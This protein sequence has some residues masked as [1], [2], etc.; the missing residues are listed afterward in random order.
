MVM[1]RR[2]AIQ[3]LG[4]FG[5]LLL[6]E[7]ANAQSTLSIERAGITSLGDSQWQLDREVAPATREFAQRYLIPV[8]VMPSDLKTRVSI[9]V[10]VPAE[11]VPMRSRSQLRYQLAKVEG[12]AYQTPITFDD[13]SKG[14]NEDA[15][16]QLRYS[17]DTGRLDPELSGLYT[18][19]IDAEN[20][21]QKQGE[22]KF[23][24]VVAPR[25]IYV[26]EQKGVL[27]DG[28]QIDIESLMVTDIKLPGAQQTLRSVDQL[29]GEQGRVMVG[30][31][32]GANEL[33]SGL[34]RVQGS[35]RWFA[36]EKTAGLVTKLDSYDSNLI[37]QAS[38]FAGAVNF[39]A[40]GL[41]DSY[42]RAK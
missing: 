38:V 11:S 2:K 8:G 39:L 13:S 35:N 15:L 6:G 42:R 37:A 10:P 22:G 1:N 41:L 9:Y 25:H 16:H 40:E 32:L 24:T 18:L 23:P 26:S 12:D 14:W 33:D 31:I 21:M 30:G 29:E 36:G 17:R 20:I 5:A 3:T 34:T 4:G 7:N 19:V 28:E 27:S